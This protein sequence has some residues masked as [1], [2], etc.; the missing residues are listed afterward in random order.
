[1]RNL[2][3][4]SPSLKSHLEKVFEKAYGDGREIVIKATG[5]NPTTFPQEP[6][7]PLEQVLDKDW[8]PFH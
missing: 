8:F 5:L 7:A 6:I 4:D 2:L 3:E 1:M